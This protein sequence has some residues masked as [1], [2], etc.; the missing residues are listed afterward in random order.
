MID[1][2]AKRLEA[3]PP[4]LTMK[5]SKTGQTRGAD[6]DEVFQNRVSRNSTVLIPHDQYEKCSKPDDGS[7][8]YGKGFIV[9]LDPAWYFGEPTADQQLASEG[10]TIGQN[11]LLYFQ[12]QAHWQAYGNL[13]R[14]P[15]GERLAPATSRLAP[16]G[17]TYVARV[18]A[19]TN[20][21]T[22]II[23]GYAKSSMRGA[24]IRVYEYAS[25]STIAKTKLQLE[26]LVW[27]CVDSHK[28]VVEAGM[29]SEGAKRRAEAILAEAEAKG[30]LDRERL[31]QMRAINGDNQ[32]ICPLCRKLVEATGFMRRSKQAA[33]RETWDTKITPVN[34]FHIEELR[35]GSLLHR[36][37][38]LGWGDHHCN[39]VAADKGIPPTLD[40]MKEVIENNGGMDAIA[41]EKKLIE[42]A[43]ER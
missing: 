34:L 21:D 27:L 10:L 39:V 25:S 14:L 18:H 37:Y 9:L 17:G 26:A 41:H 22:S 8:C 16:L 13:S 19:T 7:D 24:G 43:V 35:P 15:N 1:A 40:W 4:L 29:S 30:L 36:P 28:A 6:T 32:T 38:N 2:V 42:E 33:G 23:E 5:I 31:R 12:R 11:A 20:V 3:L